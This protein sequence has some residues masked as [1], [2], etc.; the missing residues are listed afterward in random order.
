LKRCFRSLLLII[1]LL[2]TAA[3]QA[4]T[5]PAPAPAAAPAAAAVN[6]ATLDKARKVIQILRFEAV[7]QRLAWS[8]VQQVASTILSAN[9]N[10]QKA[11]EAYVKE[12]LAP[13]VQ[14]RLPALETQ[15]AVIMATRFSD[16]ELT[17]IL[18]FY[19]SPLGNKLLTSGEPVAKDL[20]KYANETWARQVWGEI[21][22]GVPAELKK[23]GL[24][25]P[26]P[27]PAPK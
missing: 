17:Q 6:P 22:P 8:L 1:P 4:Q 26:P 25:V 24:A 12:S 15:Q 19:Q 13:A 9:K 11:I 3:A 16:A 7:S 27:P 20:L 23:R 14:K 10:K 5:A 18:A 21:G 2:L